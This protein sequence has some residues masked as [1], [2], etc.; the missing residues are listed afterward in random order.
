MKKR[1]WGL[2]ILMLVAVVF[3]AGAL[4]YWDAAVNNEAL[5]KEQLLSANFNLA[6]AYEEKALSKAKDIDETGIGGSDDYRRVLLLALQAQ[7]LPL[8]AGKEPLRLAA[9]DVLSR[10]AP[11]TAFAQRW[12]SPALD[13]GSVNALAFS[14]DGKLLA[15]DSHDETLRLWNPRHTYLML[16]PGVPSPRAALI[17]GALQRLWGLRVDGLDVKPYNWVG[18]LF[19]RDGY[20]VDQDITLGDEYG[21]YAGRTFNIRPL[22]NPPESGEDKLD[23]LLRWLEDQGM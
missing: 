11:R 10:P 4:W 3:M 1:A 7:Q 12:S 21:E 18:G 22:L 19:P 17:S 23:Q 13:L 8:P 15:S 9:R 5:A 16:N 14:P 2:G 20:Y 6:R